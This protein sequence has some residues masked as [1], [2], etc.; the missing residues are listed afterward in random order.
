MFEE[1]VL[2]YFNREL[3]VGLGDIRN[4]W[5]LPETPVKLIAAIH[6]GNLVYRIPGSRK[7]ISYQKLK[8][9]L[10]KKG[11][12]IRQYYELLPF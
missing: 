4:A 3:N 11:I 7:R 1:I 9:G 5:L 8:K 10:V 6:Q 2:R 12:V